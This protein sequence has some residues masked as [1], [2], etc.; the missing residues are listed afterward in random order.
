MVNVIMTRATDV[1]VGLNERAYLANRNK[2]DLFVSYHL[3]AAVASANGYED[4]TYPTKNTATI[5]SRNTY[6]GAVLPALRALQQFNRGKKVANFA[7]LRETN[8]PAYLMELGFITNANEYN[9]MAGQTNF[10]LLAQTHASAIKQALANLG[11]PNG[12]VCI[13]PGHG[14]RDPG[15]V[16]RGYTE[17]AYVL[18]FA[19]RVRDILQGAKPIAPIKDKKE[20]VTMLNSTGRKEIRELLK[21]ARAAGI[22]DAK[23]H[24]DEKIAKYNDVQLLSYQAAVVN[25]EFK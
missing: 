8:M 21:K 25:R 6:H 2:A 17:A 14:G 18:R 10:E 16:S 12:T 11:K 24:T 13:D 5:N 9:T 4:F 23:Y 19:L 7:V 22:I 3:N 20:D 15:A 1:Y